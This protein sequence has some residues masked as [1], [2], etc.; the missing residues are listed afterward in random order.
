MFMDGMRFGHLKKLPRTM[1]VVDTYNTLTESDRDAIRAAVQDI[2][3]DFEERSTHY[4]LIILCK[5]VLRFNLKN[6]LAL[7]EGEIWFTR[8]IFS[9]ATLQDALEYYSECEIRNGR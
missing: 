2:H 6:P 3:V 5:A 9:E 8:A 1:L 4:A 7:A